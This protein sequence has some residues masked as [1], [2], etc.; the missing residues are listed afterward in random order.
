[1]LAPV[2]RCG[3]RESALSR[4]H[5]HALVVE[6]REDARA[7]IVQNQS[8]RR[9]ASSVPGLPTA[10]RQCWLIV[11]SRR[12]LKVLHFNVPFDV[13]TILVRGVSYWSPI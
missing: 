4:S 8:A 5:G 2:L 12:F 11:V 3:R 9:T 7:G 6:L 1:M 13:L 10:L